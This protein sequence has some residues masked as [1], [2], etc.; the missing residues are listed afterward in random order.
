MNTGDFVWLRP[1][2]KKMGRS[3]SDDEMAAAMAAKVIIGDDSI[4]RRKYR[5][6][7]LAAM[8]EARAEELGK[9]GKG[10]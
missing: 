3:F 10:R 1:I 6:V 4:D 9:I 5:R 7:I 2:E 8:K